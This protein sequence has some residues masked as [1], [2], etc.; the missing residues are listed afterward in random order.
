MI[1]VAGWAGALALLSAYGLLTTGRLQATERTCT[2]LNL[3][4]SA[5]LALHGAAHAAWPSTALNL[6]WLTIALHGLHATRRRT[7]PLT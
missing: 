6:I 3:A 2:G 1:Q 5:G 4:G 7:S